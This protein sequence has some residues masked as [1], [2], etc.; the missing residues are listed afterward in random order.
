MQLYVNENLTQLQINAC[1]YLQQYVCVRREHI[2][3]NGIV[4]FQNEELLTTV[5]TAQRVYIHV[6]VH[7]IG[8]CVQR[9]S[10]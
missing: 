1:I 4:D 9:V 6:H 8:Q 10:I 5:N 3:L 2:L 7:C